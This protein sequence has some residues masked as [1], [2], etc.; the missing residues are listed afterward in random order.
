LSLTS[1]SDDSGEAF[2][3]TANTSNGA[4]SWKS[5]VGVAV[6]A[7]PGRGGGLTPPDTDFV[8]LGSAGSDE[9]GASI[10]TILPHFGHVTICPM[11][12]VSRTRNFAWQ[13]VQAIENDSNS[14]PFS[15]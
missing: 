14:Y 12:D 4:E 6:L 1:F 9:E 13:V 15:V 2:G 7:L 3:A 11:A 8:P 5:G 10:N